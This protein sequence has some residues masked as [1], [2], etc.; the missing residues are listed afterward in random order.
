MDSTLPAAGI[1]SQDTLH[2]IPEKPV[3]PLPN[4][5]KTDFLHT[6]NGPAVAV[7]RA[8][9]AIL[10]NY[11]NEDGSVRIPEVLRPYMAGIEFIPKRN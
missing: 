2:C 10:E 8:L 1:C 11:Q 9:V 7:S 5:G 3:C 6:L 4:D